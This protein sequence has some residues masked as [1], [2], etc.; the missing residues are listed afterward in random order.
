[1]AGKLILTIHITVTSEGAPGA[2]YYVDP[3]EVEAV[4]VIRV[5]CPRS[6]DSKALDVSK[7]IQG[8]LPAI[9]DEHNENWKR[10]YDRVKEAAKPSLF[11]F[12]Q[13]P[14]QDNG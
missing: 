3:D 13:Q 1:M 11:T 10:E 5:E 8:S 9:I 7:V 4:D 14:E 12:A 2:K 6:I